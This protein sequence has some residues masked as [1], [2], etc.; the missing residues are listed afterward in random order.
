[1]TFIKLLNNGF[2]N[3][4][5]INNG[6][7]FDGVGIFL[8]V[9]AILLCCLIGYFLG[10]VNF[11][12]IL[13]RKYHDDVRDHGSKNAGT[14]NMLRTYGKKAALLTFLGD[15]LKAII[16]CFLG[17]FCWGILGA[18][19][20]GLFC[21]IGHVFPVFFKFKGG[22]G[23]ATTAGV[24]LACDV[25]TFL[26]IFVLYFG[27][28]FLSKF[29]S[30]ASI[31]SALMYPFILFELNKLLPEELKVP[32]FCVLL[33]MAISIIVIVK[34]IENIKRILNGTEPRT[35][36]FGKN[37]VEKAQDESIQSKRSLH[38]EED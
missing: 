32:G 3:L 33:A 12:I 37:K 29:V 5:I 30:A 18:Y 31:M 28:F 34:H 1:M 8:T 27:V 14:T 9:L 11:A 10:S 7:V 6:G 2:A 19:L 38:N 4:Y 21:V 16:V 25:P 15:F 26:I 35:H 24:M 17:R 13:S 36:L 23:V 22:K 20:A